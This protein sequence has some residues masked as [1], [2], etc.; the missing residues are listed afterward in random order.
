MN[1]R[2][3]AVVGV[4][5]V[6]AA[7]ANALA[8]DA[9][10]RRILLAD[11]K[12]EIAIAEAM[13][14]SDALALESPVEIEAVDLQRAARADLIVL[15]AG[16]S[17][18]AGRTRLD[19]QEESAEVVR[20][21]V[22]RL[23]DGGF[24]GVLVVVSNP[25]DV[26]AELAHRV[27]GLP[28]G[29]TIG[30]G[31]LLD[32]FRLRR[33]LA[34]RAGVAPESVSAAVIGEHGD[35]SVSILSSATVGGVPLRAFGEFDRNEVQ[36][37]VRGRAGEIV[38][39]KGNTSRGI[40]AAVARIVRAVLRDERAVFPV[41]ARLAGEYGGRDLFFSTPCLLGEGGILRR[42]EADLD[43]AERADAEL[44]LNVLRD[45]VGKLDA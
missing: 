14:L 28:E 25:A 30:S 4:G 7:V 37:L 33:L 35:S 36:R 45:A 34:E 5:A 22:T 3:V 8:V 6:G 40:G 10:P 1:G 32:S 24:G 13:D 12:P 44:S 16:K 19:L 2:T 27:S 38:E 20:E 26:M 23:R 15:A 11:M 9:A 39:G 43:G 18:L 17:G 41:A 42:F 31:T 29:R 21:A